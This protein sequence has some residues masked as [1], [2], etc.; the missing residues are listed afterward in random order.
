MA[1]KGRLDAP[2]VVRCCNTLP[3]YV[4][5][6]TILACLVSLAEGGRGQCH[7]NATQ[8]RLGGI[9]L[10]TTGGFVFAVGREDHA[11]DPPTHISK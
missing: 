10:A 8:G 1:P 7:F 6:G 9:K 4:D 3:Y 2:A 11:V 5:E